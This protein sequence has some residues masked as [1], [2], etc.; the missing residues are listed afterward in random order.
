MEMHN[1]NVY[2]CALPQY[3]GSISPLL[4]TEKRSHDLGPGD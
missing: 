3:L 4:T 1:L 2:K